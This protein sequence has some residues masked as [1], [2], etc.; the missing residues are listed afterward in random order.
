MMLGEK[1]ELGRVCYIRFAM[2]PDLKQILWYNS[3]VTSEKRFWAKLGLLSGILSYIG[4]YIHVYDKV[5]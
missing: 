5:I 3:N 2:I 4:Y 1:Q